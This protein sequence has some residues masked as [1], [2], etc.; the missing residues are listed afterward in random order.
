MKKGILFTCLLILVISSLLAMSCTS[1]STPVPTSAPATTAAPT[2]TGPVKGGSLTMV[3]GF[4]PAGNQVGIPWKYNA[5]VPSFLP[6]VNEPLITSDAAGNLKPWL[7]TSWKIADDFLSITFDLRKDVKFSDGTP[8]NAEAA[9]WNI[10][11]QI[12]GKAPTSGLMKSVEATGE[13]SFKINLSG[14]DATLMNMMT[15][16]IQCLSFISPT[17]YKANGETGA[18]SKLVGTGPFMLTSWDMNVGAKFV[19]NPNYWQPG[20]PNLDEINYKFL[21][22]PNAAIMTVMSGQADIGYLFRGSYVDQK[23]A[24]EKAGYPMFYYKNGMGVYGA[25]P[26]SVNPTS[27]LANAKLREAIE[28]ATDKEALCKSVGYGLWTPTWQACPPGNAAYNPNLTARKFDLAKAKALI[29][30]SKYNGTDEINL[31]V[32]NTDSALAQA[33]QSMWKAAGINAKIVIFDQPSWVAKMNQGWTNGYLV[34]ALGA[35]PIWIATLPRYFASPP[36]SYVSMA[37]SADLN[38]ALADA[39]ASKDLAG[40]IAKTKDMIKAIN[41]DAMMLPLFQHEADFNVS[42]KIQDFGFDVA[43]IWNTADIWKK[44]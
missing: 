3:T 41:D 22:D 19:K 36:I 6:P 40:L 35:N 13:Y 23:S 5:N 33:M 30:E 10:E 14:W 42:N 11:Q 7:A 43:G 31:Y 39:R 38:K 27:P 8:L 29:A 28:Y 34:S 24:M 17:A 20:K 12:A 1:S 32:L 26:D 9:K 18:Q 4:L 25:F 15:N 16:Y 44:K 37:R 2:A 21:S